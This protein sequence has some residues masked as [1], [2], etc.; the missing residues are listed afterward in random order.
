MLAITTPMRPNRPHIPSYNH[1]FKERSSDKKRVIRQSLGVSLRALS[2]D[3]PVLRRGPAAASDRHLG[4]SASVEGYLRMGD[5]ARKREKHDTAKI[6]Q[7]G[8]K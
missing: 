1:N 8:G 7:R 4:V 2:S 5:D 3:F 6:F